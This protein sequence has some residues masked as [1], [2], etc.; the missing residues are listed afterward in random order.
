MKYLNTY[1]LFEFTNID[2]NDVGGDVEMMMSDMEDLGYGY[3]VTPSRSSSMPS[4]GFIKYGINIL[5]YRKGQNSIMVED[6][7]YRINQ[8]KDII[9]YELESVTL[10]FA[11]VNARH[12]QH[13]KLETLENFSIKDGLD[14]TNLHEVEFQ[15]LE[16]GMNNWLE[17]FSYVGK[18]SEG[19]YKFKSEMQWDDFEVFINEKDI[20]TDVRPVIKEISI[21][22]KNEIPDKV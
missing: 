21:I 5:L 11:L 9:K 20:E 12:T 17:E 8:I 10:R 19:D 2:N 1:K 13:L 3:Q 22:F 7:D 6:I 14:D 16:Y 4:N 15:V 18:D